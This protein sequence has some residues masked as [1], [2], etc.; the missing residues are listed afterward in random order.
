MIAKN[1]TTKTE[2]WLAIIIWGVILLC[3]IYIYIYFYYIF[4]FIFLFYYPNYTDFTQRTVLT[5]FCR[6]ISISFCSSSRK[7]QI[8]YSEWRDSRLPVE[9][10]NDKI[11]PIFSIRSYPSIFWRGRQGKHFL[12]TP[13]LIS[14]IKTALVSDALGEMVGCYAILV[15]FQSNG[16]HICLASPTGLFEIL[17]FHQSYRHLL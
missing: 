4:L 11:N 3:R 6:R 12:P 8:D 15:I 1:S 14:K 9:R 7:Y 17:Q 16:T 10:E 2:N 5:P 13:T